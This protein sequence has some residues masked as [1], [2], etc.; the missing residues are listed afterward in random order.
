MSS[1]SDR[2]LFWLLKISKI[3]RVKN[4]G[5]NMSIKP[6]RRSLHARLRPSRAGCSRSCNGRRHIYI[7]HQNLFFIP[8][9]ADDNFFESSVCGTFFCFR[10]NG[11]VVVCAW[12]LVSGRVSIF[13][14]QAVFFFACFFH[15]FAFE[16]F[17]DK[18]LSTSHKHQIAGSRKSLTTTFIL[19][20]LVLL[21]TLANLTKETKNNIL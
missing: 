18:N 21:L 12:V 19:T 4:R 9:L 8:P 17:C 7:L 10:T 15:F 14:C 11:A 3:H 16:V 20:F 13:H 6:L 5:G 1:S 2:W